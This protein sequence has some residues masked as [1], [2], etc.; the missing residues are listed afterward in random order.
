MELSVEVLKAA[1]FRGPVA[2][3]DGAG[4]MA[5]QDF[6]CI[7][8][9][10]FGYFWQRQDRKDKGRQAYMVDGKEVAD[11]D[12]ACRLLAL[13]V[14]P[15]SPA[16]ISKRSL[17]EFQASPPLNYGATRALSE[18]RCNADAGP[19]GMV[20]AMMH[21]ADHAWHVGINRLADKAR[22]AGEEWPRWLYKTKSAAHESYRG[23]YLFAA[24]REKDTGLVCAKAVRCR[25]CPILQEIDAS[26]AEAR[27]NQKWPS[28]AEDSDVDAAKV[29]TCIGHILTTQ[30]DVM[31]G[32]FF[33]TESLS[34]SKGLF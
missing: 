15:E 12:E 31:D 6:Q 28:A 18:A 22:T 26:Y 9:P 17:A 20:R 30:A 19:F 23:M 8:E 34:K 14:D 2:F 27:A 10:R 1:K 3:Y 16:E 13:P 21:R 4:G 7:E 29:W 11:L 5:R 32:E 24:D 33:T 25:D